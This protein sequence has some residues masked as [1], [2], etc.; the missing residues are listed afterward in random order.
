MVLV[1]VSLF[2]VVQKVLKAG[3]EDTRVGTVERV[4]DLGV[5]CQMP[6]VAAE[7]LT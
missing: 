2:A 6:G 1:L 5:D 7:F 3:P 4:F